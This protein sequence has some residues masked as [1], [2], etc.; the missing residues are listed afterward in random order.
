MA[1]VRSLRAAFDYADQP[2][3]LIETSWPLWLRAPLALSPRWRDVWGRLVRAR[4]PEAFLE[5]DTVLLRQAVAACVYLEAVSDLCLCE[6][7]TFRET[8]HS[9][10]LRT[11]LELL[12]VLHL[13][14]VDRD[15]H[16]VK[17]PVEFTE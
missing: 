8:A 5:A 11:Y 3:G 1:Q 4:G 17:R 14:P 13:R 7:Q 9:V 12:R 15:G 16:T 10:A 6:G 2:D